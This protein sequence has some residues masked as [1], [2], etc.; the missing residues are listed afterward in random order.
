[1]ATSSSTSTSCYISDEI[2]VEMGDGGLELV[3]L[4]SG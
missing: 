1:M 2:S 3:E 4:V